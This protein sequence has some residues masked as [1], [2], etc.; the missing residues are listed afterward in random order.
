MAADLRCG[1]AGWS[2]PHWN[3]VVYPRPKS[4]TFHPLEYLAGYF[5]TVEINSTFY[6][7]V[8]PEIARLWSSL[9]SHNR[10]FQFTAKLSRRFTHDRD[11]NS[12]EVQ[13]FRDGIEPLQVS[14]KLGCVLMQFPW[15]F[16]YTVENRDFFIKLRRAFHQ[17]PLV[18]EMRHSSWAAEE[19]VGTFIDYRVGFCNIDQ[20]EYEKAMPPTSFLTSSTGYVRL[21]GRPAAGMLQGFEE[22]AQD[23]NDY[24]YSTSEL[25]CWAGRIA[26]IR[27]YAA[28]VFVITTNDAAGKSVVNAL[29]L[30]GMLGGRQSGIPGD[31]LRRHR[32]AFH[33]VHQ[34]GPLQN[35]LFGDIAIAQSG[36]AVA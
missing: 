5:D 3:S 2:Y 17:F 22:R 1:P 32:A 26:N 25:Q 10:A 20:P 31:L 18:A 33:A 11:L 6:A 4:R 23:R 30:Q 12:V 29:Q 21:H 8:R 9:V 14:G 27:Q 19:A 28:S 15:S 36:R 16:R 35:S 13:A 24:L 34:S 7:P